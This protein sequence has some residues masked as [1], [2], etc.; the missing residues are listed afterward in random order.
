MSTTTLSRQIFARVAPTLFVVALAVGG[1]AYHGARQEI[2]KAY[3]AQ[4][5]SDANVLWAIVADELKEAAEEGGKGF[6][7]ADFSVGNQLA[8]N[9]LADDYTDAHMFRV[10]WKNKIVM[11]SHTAPAAAM[12][13]QPAGFSDV[14]DRGIP[15][16]I[17]ALQLP[18]KIYS[19][20]VGE[21]PALRQLLMRDILFDLLLPL[22]LLIPMSGA[23]IWIGING[24]LGKIRGLVQQ[25][26][27]R[28]PETLLPVDMAGLPRD[29]VPL[30]DALNQLLAKLE[31]SFMAEKRFVDD[32]AHHLRTPIAVLRLQL[33]MLSQASDEGE[34]ATLIHELLQSNDRAS[35]LVGQLLVSARLGYQPP[36]LKSVS[37][38]RAT[39]ST[40]AELG[41]LA[42]EKHIQMSLD[43]A[44]DAAVMAEDALL[45][46][47]LTNLV[48]NAIKYTPPGG[49]VQVRID[50]AGTA[51]KLSVSDTGPGI[52]E[53]QRKQVFE[54]FHRLDSPGVEGSGLGLSIVADVVKRF[55]GSVALKD[56]TAG[57]GLLVE[58]M[59]PRA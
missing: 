40:M 22:I 29:L 18:G 16:R 31:R 26:G 10:W 20:E 24:G 39:A 13:P 59:L 42:S 44:E 23:L 6:G 19:I 50:D 52:P 51:W 38:S 30:V 46:L 56:A 32:A 37:L 8:L 5:I 14:S 35:K 48:E 43:G 12:P 45:H 1:L 36:V 3:D 54:R 17:Y 11:F 49:R 21:K 4:M 25:I 53:G 58:I 34:R 33:Q 27:A 2:N 47:M 28:S 7:E 41:V 57:A 55:S 15:W 9:D